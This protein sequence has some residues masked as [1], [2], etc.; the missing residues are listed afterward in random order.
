MKLNIHYSAL[1]DTIII[2]CLGFGYSEI[3][4]VAC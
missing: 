2:G 3:E 4:S 1:M